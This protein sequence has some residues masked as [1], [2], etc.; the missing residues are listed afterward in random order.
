[1]IIFDISQKEV[2]KIRA[3]QGENLLEN[4]EKLK[5]NS[6]VLRQRGKRTTILFTPLSILVMQQISFVLDLDQKELAKELGNSTLVKDTLKDMAGIF[7]DSDEETSILVDT[8]LF[9]EF[10]DYI[11]SRVNHLINTLN[12]E[13]ATNNQ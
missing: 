6:D 10:V 13:D 12:D 5:S 2:N 7:E 4:L 3:K 1:M 9:N 8:D 11:T